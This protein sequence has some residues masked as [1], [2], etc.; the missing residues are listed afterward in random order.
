MDL[1]LITLLSGG[2]EVEIRYSL[3]GKEDPE[4]FGPPCLPILTRSK[5][6]APRTENPLEMKCASSCL[7]KVGPQQPDSGLV[8]VDST[9]AFSSS[10]SHSLRYDQPLFALRWWSK[11]F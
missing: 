1:G 7:R 4:D 6:E 3:A 5:T 10:D 2:S 11:S 9:S 8:A